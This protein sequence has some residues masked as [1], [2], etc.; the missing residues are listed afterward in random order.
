MNKELTPA[1]ASRFEQ[2]FVVAGLTVHEMEAFVNLH[3]AIFSEIYFPRFINNLYLDSPSL[4]NYFSHVNGF[5]DRAKVRIRWY[6]SLFGL[7]DEPVLELK[8][9]RGSVGTKESYPLAPFKMD[10]RLPL[11]S[12]RNLFTTSGIPE[13][14]RLDLISLEASLVIRYRRKYFQSADRKYRLTVDTELEFYQPRGANNSL[15]RE[16]IGP[17]DTILELKYGLNEAGEVKRITNWFPFRMTKISKY[18]SGIH[19]VYSW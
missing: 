14:L 12:I 4:N 7:V 16:S 2:K 9:K 15:L 19:R 3:P 6:G 18:V 5:K 13:A 17:I 1:N 10:K 11:D 8:I